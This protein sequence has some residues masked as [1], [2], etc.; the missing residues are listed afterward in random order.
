MTSDQGS[1]DDLLRGAGTGDPH[2]LAEL[3]AR[4]RSRLR[5]MV[6]LRLDRRL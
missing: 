5:R 1:T 6:R 4:Y 3:F 2:A